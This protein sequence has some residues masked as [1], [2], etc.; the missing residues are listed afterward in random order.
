MTAVLRYERQ[1]SRCSSESKV[2]PCKPAM[3]VEIVQDGATYPTFSSR[4]ERIKDM[5]Q[6]QHGQYT[7][8]TDEKEVVHITA[9][10]LS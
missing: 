1:V 2:L 7:E 5:K 4:Y 3:P 8:I 10:I 9:Y 6:N